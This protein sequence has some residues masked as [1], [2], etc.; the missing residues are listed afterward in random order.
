MPTAPPGLLPFPA[1]AATSWQPGISRA[2]SSLQHLTQL[3]HLQLRFVCGERGYFMCPAFLH[4]ASSLVQL[5]HLDLGY[6]EVTPAALAGLAQLQQ[7]QCLTLYGSLSGLSA[8]DY[9][10]LSSLRSLQRLEMFHDWPP[11]LDDAAEPEDH[12][13]DAQQL[14][15]L[16]VALGC[17][18]QLSWLN[19]PMSRGSSALLPLL[20]KLPALR[21]LYL[22]SIERHQV[23]VPIASF[24][25]AAQQLRVLQMDNVRLT[26]QG[27]ASIAKL[28]QLQQLT[29]FNLSLDVDL[30]VQQCLT[31]L[32]QLSQL[33]QLCFD[34]LASEGPPSP[35]VLDNAALR[36]DQVVSA[37]M[38]LS[39]LAGLEACT[40]VS[41][42]RF[43]TEGAA[44]REVVVDAA[45]LPPRLQSLC[46]C[47]LTLRN[48][49]LLP[50]TL[51]HLWF[52]DVS[53]PDLNPAAPQNPDPAH[54]LNLGHTLAGRLPLL[55]TLVLRCVGPGGPP[56]VTTAS[57]AA[58][59]AGAGLGLQQLL[60]QAMPRVTVRPAT[61]DWFWGTN[62]PLGSCLN[63]ENP[64][65]WW[66]FTAWTIL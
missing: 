32:S 38:L 42:Y 28:T 62:F 29:L 14:Q 61:N 53:T 15:Q 35:A 2:L 50:Q 27:L 52:T 60:Q 57:L 56:S 64:M 55:L 25:A 30:G 48:A 31:Q 23:E 24:A 7:L 41:L 44:Q 49:Q 16:G 12:V 58:I 22:Q 47:T 34:S 66:K 4:V 20:Q 26:A 18:T 37:G 36:F 19:L 5:T 11:A 40:N 45:Q 54:H 10:C 6:V 63:T 46:L 13:L 51:E 33:Q 65:E 3:R 8:Q 9:G 17:L 59:A 39:S 43:Q 1:A 21:Q